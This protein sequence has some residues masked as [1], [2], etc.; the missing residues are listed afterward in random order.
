M[1]F[2]AHLYRGDHVAAVFMCQNDPGECGEWDPWL[3]ANR[4]RLFAA[5]GLAPLPV[6]EDGNT[7]LAATTAL[8]PF[9][10]DSAG[11]EDIDPGTWG[12]VLGRLGGAPR[13]LQ[14]DQTPDCP[15]CGVVMGLVAQFECGRSLAEGPFF[16]GGCAYLFACVPCSEAVYLWQC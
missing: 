9:C 14:A 5:S 8:T 10:W 12:T 13:W 16:G 3:G 7:L 11:Y 6:P 2:V 15:G 1:Q 4:A